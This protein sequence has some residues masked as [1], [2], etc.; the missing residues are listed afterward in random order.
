MKTLLF[1]AVLS[2]SL[3]AWAQSGSR[4]TI[5]RN[6]VAGGGTLSSNVTFSLGSTVGEPVPSSSNTNNRFTVRSGFWIRPA[7]VVFAPHVVGNNF[8]LSF[9]TEPGE[10]YFAQFADSLD[11]SAWQSLPTVSGNGA[12]Q[13]ATNSAPGASVRFYRIVQQ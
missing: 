7:P 10:L 3:P 6:A 11:G 5:T 1:L 13:S 8:V 2:L 9:E 4:F 12:I